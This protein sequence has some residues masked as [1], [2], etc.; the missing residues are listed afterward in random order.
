MRIGNF[1]V[2]VV[3]PDGGG[4]AFPEVVDP[5]T[6]T[7]Y[8]VAEPGSLYGVKVSLL[9]SSAKKIYR[10]SLKVEFNSNWGDHLT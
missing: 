10:F 7:T 8:V 2:S 9:E 4:A 5:V 1:S 6:N 3:H